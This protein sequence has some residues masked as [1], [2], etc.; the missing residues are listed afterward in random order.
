MGDIAE[1]G[2]GVRAHG[3]MYALVA[4]LR[5][6]GLTVPEDAGRMA[7]GMRAAWLEAIEVCGV[8]ASNEGG[9]TTTARTALRA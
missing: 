3:T 9:R 2:I 5:R 4:A 7:E 8:P 6:A 1:R